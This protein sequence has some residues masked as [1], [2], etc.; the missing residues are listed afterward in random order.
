MD[1]DGATG[2]AAVVSNE[3]L[4]DGEQL[5]YLDWIGV[6]GESRYYV[7]G[8][9][10]EVLFE[11]IAG[12]TTLYATLTDHLGTYRDLVNTSGTTINHIVY[13]S[14]GKIISETLAT[15]NSP[16]VRFTGQLFDYQAGLNY[17]HHRWYDPSAGRWISED[18]IGFAGGD[19]NLNR[20]VGNSPAMFV[21]P[22]GLQSAIDRGRPIAF[23]SRVDIR[24][25]GDR[26]TD[27]THDFG[28]DMERVGDKTIR[29]IPVA[30]TAIAV[31]ETVTG[32]NVTMPGQS[33]NETDNAIQIASVGAGYGL[34]KIFNWIRGVRFADDAADIGKGAGAGR[35]GASGAGGGA[36]KPAQGAPKPPK[37]FIPPTNAPSTPKIPDGW[38]SEPTK[39]GRG[40]IY[41]PPGTTGD[42][43]TIRVMNPTPDYPNGY[44]RQYD[45][46]GVAIDPATGKPGNAGN[47]HVPLPPS[48]SQFSPMQR[49]SN[50]MISNPWRTTGSRIWL[51]V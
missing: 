8:P 14:Y 30:G 11:Q 42:A 22:T 43:N 7:Y 18:P 36:G 32:Q 4:W 45:G 48:A 1:P 20:Y 12:Y 15:P 3:Y 25:H 10:G 49:R 16:R 2:S 44:W 26:E 29:N 9:T 35:P 17:H 5:V 21:D 51:Y 23:R 24:E 46:S 31:T 39:N 33:V 41:R 28:Q 34:A 50:D 27:R 47:T 40:T 38:I 13:D 19:P 6:A 37:V